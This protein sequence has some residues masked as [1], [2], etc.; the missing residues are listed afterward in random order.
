MVLILDNVDMLISR[1]LISLDNVERLG[2]EAIQLILDA[3]AQSNEETH[4]H[5]HE[6]NDWFTK[7]VHI[8]PSKEEAEKFTVDEVISGNG[9]Y[10]GQVTVN[11]FHYGYSLSDGRYVGLFNF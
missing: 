7:Y 2:R 4:L 3:D 8:L 6:I 9:P 5:A 1:G 10:S 11:R